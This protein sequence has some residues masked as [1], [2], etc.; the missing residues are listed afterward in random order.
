MS[1]FN[2]NKADIRHVMESIESES[3]RYVVHAG[4]R[5]FFRHLVETEVL[6]ASP[7]DGMRP[8]ATPEER[9][10]CLNE[11]ELRSVVT[12][13]NKMDYPLR[14]YFMLLIRLHREEKKS[15]AWRGGSCS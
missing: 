3:V 4:L 2:V 6:A 7:M 15:A 8:P 9:E 12:A 5:T 13:I 11:E 10:R 14:H 1:V